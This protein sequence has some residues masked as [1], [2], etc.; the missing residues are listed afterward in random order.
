M[1]RPINTIIQTIRPNINNYFG[2]NQR[3]H[4]ILVIGCDRFVYMSR[5]RLIDRRP[6]HYP[7]KNNMD[8]DVYSVELAQYPNEVYHLWN[9]GEHKFT[10]TDKTLLSTHSFNQQPIYQQAHGAIVMCKFRIK[11]HK[12][13]QINHTLGHIPIV[14]TTNCNQYVETTKYEE[15]L[16]GEEYVYGDM[17]YPLNVLAY[18]IKHGIK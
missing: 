11:T 3:P 15:T 8:I 5:I 10:Q 17:F 18:K 4:N 1:L 12:I 13:K 2:I 9:C 14:F 16:Y 7:I 6:L